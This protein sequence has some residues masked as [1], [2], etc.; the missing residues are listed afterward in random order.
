MID[1]QPDLLAT[2]CGGESFGDVIHALRSAPQVPL[3]DQYATTKGFI[4]DHPFFHR[5][6]M[7]LPIGGGK[8]F[9]NV[10]FVGPWTSFKGRLTGNRDQIMRGHE[11]TR[12]THDAP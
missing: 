9:R 11:I 4:A 7:N 10:A 3:A 2:V 8:H 1:I 5:G 12:A 6:V